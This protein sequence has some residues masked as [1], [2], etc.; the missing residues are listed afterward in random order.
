MVDRAH[1]LGLTTPEMVA[2]VG[3]MR[4]LGGNHVTG[5]EMCTHGVL[6]KNVGALTTDFFINLLD[7]E[8]SWEKG[9]EEGLYTGKN[10]VTC[11]EMY[12]ATQVDLSIG[13]NSSLRAI[14]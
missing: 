3:G 8:I 14:A 10:R 1:L 9:E 11:E 6:T 7:M 12:T 2:L 5:D 13:S 4:V